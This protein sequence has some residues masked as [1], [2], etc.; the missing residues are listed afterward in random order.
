MLSEIIDVG[1]LA[2]L[3]ENSRI[4]EESEE[5]SAEKLLKKYN[6]SVYDEK[7]ESYFTWV[8]FAVI[9]GKLSEGINF[10]DDLGN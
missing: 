8:L 9:G 10:S 1:I 3:K 6:D 5:E 7:D 2:S 4:F